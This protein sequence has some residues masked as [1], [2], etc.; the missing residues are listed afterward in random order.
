MNNTGYTIQELN[1]LEEKIKK[2]LSKARFEHSLGVANTAVKLGEIFI[3]D[4][5]SE[6]FAA[7]LLHDVAKELDDE[8]TLDLLKNTN[9]T[10]D[11]LPDLSSTKQTTR[12]LD[13]SNENVG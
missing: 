4:R 12:C 5:C 11:M 2:R 9:L 10:E 1:T 8:K 13:L 7:G 3:S 6:L